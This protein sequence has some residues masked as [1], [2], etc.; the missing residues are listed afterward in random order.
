MDMIRRNTDYAIRAMS[1]LAV[2][3]GDGPV[4]AATIAAG[5][6]ISYPLVSKLLQRLQ[7]ARLV[8][9]SMG[10]RGGFQ[11]SRD[12]RHITLLEVIEAIQ[13]KVSLN[14]CLVRTK[15]CTR[16]RVCPVRPR[17]GGIQETL[18]EALRQTTLRDL[19]GQKGSAA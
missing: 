18:V 12:P 10:V 19:V 9:S 1:H 8:A 6:D 7:E 3:Y 15:A 14:R 17:L 13:G 4:S 11:L 2:S 5:Q 16:R